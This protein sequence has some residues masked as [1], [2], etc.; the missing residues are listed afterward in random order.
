VTDVG[1]RAGEKVGGSVRIWAHPRAVQACCPGSGD[2]SIRV[3]SR[4]ERKLVDAA[5]AGRRVK[6]RLPV[7][8][9][10][11]TAVKGVVALGEAEAGQID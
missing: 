4:Y 5:V 7:R 3:H 11:V 9:F 2:E 8:R 10:V 6:I 1:D